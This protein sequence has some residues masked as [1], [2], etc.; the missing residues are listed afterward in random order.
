MTGDI[1]GA[2]RVVIG[3]GTWEWA[4]HGLRRPPESDTTGW[5]RGTGEL[6]QGVDFFLPWHAAV[7]LVQGEIRL[8]NNASGHY[9]PFGPGAL[10]AAEQAFGSSGLTVRSGAYSEIAP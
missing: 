2:L 1:L 4:L 8:I 7:A 10:A 3:N 6:P 5:Y 9:K